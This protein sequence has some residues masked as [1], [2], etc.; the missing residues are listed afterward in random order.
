MMP[1]W[2]EV[3]SS[4]HQLSELLLGFLKECNSSLKGRILN[5]L[6]T[7]KQNFFTGWREF[8]WKCVKL[9]SEHFLFL[10]IF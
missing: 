6:G 4:F 7:L 1:T 9:V 5:N 2:V 10:K 8:Y 3:Q